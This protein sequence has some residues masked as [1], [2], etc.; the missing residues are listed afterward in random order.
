MLDTTV[1]PNGKII[2]IGGTEEGLS[3]L[4][5]KPVRASASLCNTDQGHL[6]APP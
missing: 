3:N 1:L 5:V 6:T 2:I 4:E